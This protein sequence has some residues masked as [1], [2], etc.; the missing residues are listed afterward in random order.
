MIQIKNRYTEKVLK[1]VEG[2]SLLEAYLWKADLRG[3]N[4]RG[5]NLQG[6]D[7]WKANLQEADLQEA[8]YDIMTML[9]ASWREASEEL[10]L[11]L[12]R[13]DCECLLDGEKLFEKWGREGD[14]PFSGNISRA[15]YFYE[16]KYLWKPGRPKP[17]IE[18]WAMCCRDHKIKWDGAKP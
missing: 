8:H 3:A 5:A 7:L 4:L 1:E 9:K 14:C 16:K 12:M 10:C 2:D 11:E 18:I 17:L 6:A 13:L 15:V